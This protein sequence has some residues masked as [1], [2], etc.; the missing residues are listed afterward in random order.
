[1]EPAILQQIT[2]GAPGVMVVMTAADLKEAVGEIYKA[3]KANTAAAIAAHRERPTLT[4]VEAA[5]LLNITK[6]TLWRWAKSGYLKPV[7]IGA[8]VL[9]RASDI[10]E[11]LLKRSKPQP[12][13]NTSATSL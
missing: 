7:K 11:I 10:D 5:R 2:T 1:M 6:E 3:E 9:Y 13:G 4:R 12:Y 8:K